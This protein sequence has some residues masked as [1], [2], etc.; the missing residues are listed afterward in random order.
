MQ[1]CWEIWILGNLL[2]DF[3]LILFET[4]MLEDKSKKSNVSFSINQDK[5]IAY[6]NE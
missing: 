5:N 6:V 1:L 3:V 4:S 2:S